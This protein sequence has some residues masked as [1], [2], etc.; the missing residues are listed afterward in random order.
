MLTIGCPQQVCA[1][2][3]STSTP[4]RRSSVTTAFPVSGNIAS[5][6]QVTIRATLM[7]ATLPQRTASSR[8]VRW[9]SCGPSKTLD[10]GCGRDR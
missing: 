10:F 4:S 5:L 9:T 6:T 8:R 1:A 2:G 7:A 3:K